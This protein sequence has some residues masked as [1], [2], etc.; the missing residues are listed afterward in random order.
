MG[1]DRYAT[2]LACGR[3]EKSIAVRFVS[4][5]N[6][7]HLFDTGNHSDNNIMCKLSEP[8][9][10]HH[11]HTHPH[12]TIR[13]NS[14]NMFIHDDSVLLRC[15]CSPPI[16]ITNFNGN[17]SIKTSTA[18]YFT[19]CMLWFLCAVLP[20]CRHYVSSKKETPKNIFTVLHAKRI[21]ALHTKLILYILNVTNDRKRFVRMVEEKRWENESYSLRHR[22][23]GAITQENPIFTKL[24]QT[25][26]LRWIITYCALCVCVCFWYN[27]HVCLRF[28]G[29]LS[30]YETTVKRAKPSNNR[31]SNQIEEEIK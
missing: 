21:H 5:I 18:I 15:C 9:A 17:H 2:H 11:T 3:K 13:K 25:E 27:R 10:S 23:I 26:I 22:T 4:K 30:W 20:F 19:K 8:L 6:G 12:F 7:I 29:M 31:H 24:M 28:N 1:P 16:Y 14:P